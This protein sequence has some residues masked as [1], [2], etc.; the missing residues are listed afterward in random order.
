MNTCLCGKSDGDLKGEWSE[1]E[2]E[3]A[4]DDFGI[5]LGE[6][7]GC[8]SAEGG[9]LAGDG[10]LM[11]SFGDNGVLIETDFFCGDEGVTE[12]AWWST[13]LWRGAS[14]SYTSSLVVDNVGD[15]WDDWEDGESETEFDLKGDWDSSWVGVGMNWSST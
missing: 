5:S 8:L 6:Y 13:G 12:I 7:L 4:G 1:C 15:D 14:G 3:E 2:D 9:L 10:F 11:D